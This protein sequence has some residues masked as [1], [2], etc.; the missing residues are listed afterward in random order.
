MLAVFVGR[1]PIVLNLFL[2]GGAEFVARALAV[3][4]IALSDAFLVASHN[5]T[6]LYQATKSTPWASR[7]DASSQYRSLRSIPIAWRP[8]SFAALS[9][10]PEPIIGSRTMPAGITSSSRRKSGTGFGQGWP[11]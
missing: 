8:L 1:E 6:Y 11:L 4:Q 3:R 10:V 5:G 2:I 9:V 7:L